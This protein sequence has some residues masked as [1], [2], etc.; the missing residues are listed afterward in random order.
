MPR[1]CLPPKFSS[2]I[3]FLTSPSRSVPSYG[4]AQSSPVAHSLNQSVM[5]H[6]AVRTV[7]GDWA[8]IGP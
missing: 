7:P 6:G 5:E 8:V 3:K 1:G 2:P 4:R